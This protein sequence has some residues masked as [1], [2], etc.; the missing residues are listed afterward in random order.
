MER[1]VEEGEEEGE[2]VAAVE[3]GEVLLGAEG[4]A[5]EAQCPDAL[6]LVEGTV[7]TRCII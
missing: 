6:P 4:V 5:E 2:A 3:E 1:G 7:R